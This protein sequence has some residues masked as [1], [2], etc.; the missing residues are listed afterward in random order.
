MSNQLENVKQSSDDGDVVEGN[1]DDK[2]IKAEA[3]HHQILSSGERKTL[4][5]M[6]RT[7]DQE[8]KDVVKKEKLDQIRVP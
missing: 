4:I 7:M 1:G 3:D 6:N 8:T 5:S 2:L